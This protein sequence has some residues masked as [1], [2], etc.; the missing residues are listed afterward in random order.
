MLRRVLPRDEEMLNI[1]PNQR[2]NMTKRMEDL[3]ERECDVCKKVFMPIRKG[4][5]K[6]SP[7]CR[8]IWYRQEADKRN[9]DKRARNKKGMVG[10]V[11]KVCREQFIGFKH[12][13]TCSAKCAKTYIEEGVGYRVYLLKIDQLKPKEIEV[14]VSHKE[15]PDMPANPSDSPEQLELKQAMADFKKDGGKITVLPPEPSQTI[16]SVNLLWRDGGW[17]WENSAGLGSYTGA[18]DYFHNE[19]LVQGETNG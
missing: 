17:D 13:Q 3:V 12:R 5:N 4:N 18:G 2:G 7:A 10:R 15:V 14:K 1:N 19:P 6:C 9:E 8:A 11:C 16:P